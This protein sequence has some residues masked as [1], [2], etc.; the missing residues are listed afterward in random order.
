MKALPGFACTVVALAAFASSPIALAQAYPAKAIR[1]ILPFPPGG[2]T[3]IAGR[4]IAQK[5]SEQLEQPVI[6]D[7]RPGAASNLGLELAAKSP[8]D[9]YTLVL[10]PPSIALSPSM[11]R[12]LNYDASRDLQPL[13]L[14]ANMYYVMAAHNSVPAKNLNEFIALAKRNSGKLNFSSSGLGAGNHLATELLKSMYGLQMV[15]IPYKGNVAG[16]LACATGEVDFGTF[17]L[18]PSIPMVKAKRVRPLAVLTEKRLGVVPEVP[19]AREQGVDLVSVQWYGIL[20]AAGTP[21]AI[22]DRLVSELHKAVSS[23]DV[24]D[25]LA[26]S[27]ID[28]VTSTPEQFRELIRSETALY[29]KVIKAAGIKAE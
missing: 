2:P 11:V 1:L 13:T 29:A 5:L 28:T 24:K 25:K 3:D 8:P 10:T 23:P 9:G 14:V 21:R 18:A 15:H 20:T 26:A 4:A 27:G 19:T 7:N 6:A 16:L 12:K 17:A 22:V